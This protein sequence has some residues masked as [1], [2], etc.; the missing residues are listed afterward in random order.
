MIAVA[1]MD[2]NAK[3]LRVIVHLRE[4]GYAWRGGDELHCSL[5]TSLESIVDTTGRSNNALYSIASYTERKRQEY[6]MSPPRILRME[7]M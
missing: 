2:Y 6:C 3:I 4:I 7:R 5:L 1:A